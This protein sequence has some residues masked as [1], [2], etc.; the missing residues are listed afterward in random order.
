MYL[1]SLVKFYNA[2]K[3]DQDGYEFKW[4]LPKRKH[5]VKKFDVTMCELGELRKYL[6]IACATR[7][8]KNKVW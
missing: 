4:D 8:A 2:S 5:V 1:S 3:I 7:Q 6:N